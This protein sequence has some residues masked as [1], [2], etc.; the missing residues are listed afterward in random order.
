MRFSGQ[1]YPVFPGLIWRHVKVGLSP[2]W[3]RPPGDIRKL[4]VPLIKLDPQRIAT[5][6]ATNDDRTVGPA[7]QH[8]A[9][10]QHP[11]SQQHEMISPSVMEFAVGYDIAHP[12]HPFAMIRQIPG[13]SGRRTVQAFFTDMALSCGAK[14]RDNTT[15]PGAS[16]TSRRVT[17][18]SFGRFS[19][20]IPRM[21]AT[22]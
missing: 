10:S 4:E 15:M 14:E 17:A 16:Y 21:G 3:R 19:G 18:P 11:L 9:V 6:F 20:E 5:E 2:P 12:K 13:E 1:P 8:R 22:F 7:S